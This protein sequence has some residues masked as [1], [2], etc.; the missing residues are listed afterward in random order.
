MKDRKGRSGIESEIIQQQFTEGEIN[1]VE[2]EKGSNLKTT[3]IKFVPT[4]NFRSER[5]L[6]LNCINQTKDVQNFVP[7]REKANSS[8]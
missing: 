7:S 8:T 3:P 4:R 1:E 2:S 5:K 6:H